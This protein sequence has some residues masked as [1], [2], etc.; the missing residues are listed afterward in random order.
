M[1]SEIKSSRR[2]VWIFYTLVC[3]YFFG[4]ISRARA[5]SKHFNH[6]NN[7][8]RMFLMQKSIESINTNNFFHLIYVHSKISIKNRININ[9]ASTR[10]DQFLRHPSQGVSLL[11]I[12]KHS[13]FC[14][15]LL[16]FLNIFFAPL[17]IP[18][19]TTFVLIAIS[20]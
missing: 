14:C 20:P 10:T 3:T 4:G 17:S 6:D 11:A 12:A 8:F 9:R 7:G 1:C 5:D 2:R 16:F 18:D 19:S 13:S 15:C